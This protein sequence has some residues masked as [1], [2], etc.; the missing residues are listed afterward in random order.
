MIT[1]VEGYYDPRLPEQERLNRFYDNMRELAKERALKYVEGVFVKSKKT[2]VPL[3]V[4]IRSSNIDMKIIEQE[5]YLV[6]IKNNLP[7]IK[8]AIKDTSIYN[9]LKQ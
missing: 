1:N 8:K 2:S 4:F 7:K 3:T 5:E 9:K 6:L